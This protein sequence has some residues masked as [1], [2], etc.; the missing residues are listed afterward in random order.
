MSLPDDYPDLNP[1]TIA[2]HAAAYRLLGS[3]SCLCMTRCPSCRG[4]S[5]RTPSWGRRCL[6]ACTGLLAGL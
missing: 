3:K 1:K 5:F 4:K 2:Q 6:T